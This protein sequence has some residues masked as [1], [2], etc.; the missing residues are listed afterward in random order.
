MQGKTVS[1][2]CAVFNKRVKVS[3][4]TSADMLY[5]VIGPRVCLSVCR[6]VC[7]SVCRRVQTE[8]AFF[9]VQLQPQPGHNESQYCTTGLLYITVGQ[10]AARFKTDWN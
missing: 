8:A 2:L 5:R 9:E 10:C 3:R 1:L 4:L 6:S 7:L